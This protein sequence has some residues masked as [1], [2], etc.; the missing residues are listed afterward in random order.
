VGGSKT[1]FFDQKLTE[2]VFFRNKK[3]HREREIIEKNK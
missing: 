3:E 1:V 2:R